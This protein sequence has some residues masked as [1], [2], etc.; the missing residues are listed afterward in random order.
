MIKMPDDHPERTIAGMFGITAAE[1][2]EKVAM[3][4]K[5]CSSCK[6][7]LPTS[8]FTAR[9][10]SRD[11]LDW[12]CRD[13]S[14]AIQRA[15]QRA[16]TPDQ[17]ARRNEAARAA[18]AKDPERQKELRARR[19]PPWG[20]MSGEQLR[21]AKARA[22]FHAAVSR[23]KISVPGECEQCGEECKPEGHHP[24]YDKP[25]HVE[26]LCR[27]CHARRHSEEIYG[28]PEETA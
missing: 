8:M 21:K 2:R 13:C 14:R 25:L 3:G 18:R 11:G 19:E 7:W 10:K 27:L 24:D 15:A 4:L 17:R 28:S 12:Y 9:K 1:Y 6:E 5:R 20:E 16:L 22:L 23:G 26:W